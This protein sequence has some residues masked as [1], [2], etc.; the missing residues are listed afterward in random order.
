[1]TE[2]LTSAFLWGDRHFPPSVVAQ[3]AQLLEGSDAVDYMSHST[4][5]GSF[6]PRQLWTPE[7]APMAAMMGDPDSLQDA[8]LMAA[9]SH[10]AAPSL[11]IS[12]LT[13]SIRIGPAQ[14]TQ[15]MWTLAHM[16]EGRA[17]IHFG[18]GENKQLKPFGWKKSQGLSRLEDLL[19]IFD[20][21]CTEE[22]PFDHEGR[23]WKLQRAWLGGARPFRPKVHAMGA[24]P[25][26]ID[27]ATSYADGL[28]T[29]VPCAWTTPDE[30]AEN[31]SA[32]R[33]QLE[34]KGRDPDAFRFGMFCPVLIHEDEDVLDAALDNAIVR[35]IAAT[36][37]RIQHDEWAKA[38]LSAPTPEGWAYYADFL[39]QSTDDGF[40][41]EVLSKTT[42][43]HAETGYLWGSPEQ[44]AAKLAEYVAAGIS[45]IAPADY[46]PVVG[47][48]ADAQRATERSIACLAALKASAAL[49]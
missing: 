31:I 20:R 45:F 9:Y 24:G 29:A 28:S 4:Q 22:G 25:T 36:F 10:A 39:P 18:A 40:V 8:F 27:H 12:L 1:M 17:I 34:R 11:G 15:M 7:H 44:V 33:E 35:W 6:I 23:N 13:D 3:Q 5:L 16:T 37:G 46:L 32:V 41:A 38:G 49:V 19:V 2:L 42:R 47:D 14:L 43:A 30:C 48:P 21:F 26:L